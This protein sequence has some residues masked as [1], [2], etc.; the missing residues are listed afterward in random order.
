MSLEIFVF[1]HFIKCLVNVSPQCLLY[2]FEERNFKIEK[3]KGLIFVLP[4]RSGKSMQDLIIN[5]GFRNSQIVNKR[6]WS[7]NC[8]EHDEILGNSPKVQW[9]QTR[10][11]KMNYLVSLLL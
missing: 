2:Y 3:W 7:V 6:R 10:M 5:F 8:A 11:D 4:I 9:D 1:I